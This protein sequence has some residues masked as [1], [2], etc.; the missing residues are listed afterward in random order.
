M[1]DLVRRHYDRF[2]YPGVNMLAK[3]RPCDT[4]ALNLPALWGGFN[5]VL[6]PSSQAILIAGCGTFSHY[7]FSIANPDAGIVGLDLS[8]ASLAKAKLHAR[9]H[10]CENVTF[11]QGDLLQPEVAPG[12]FH[13]IDAYGVLHHLEEPLAGLHALAD[14]LE[15]GGILRI[16]VYSRGARRTVESVRRAFRLLGITDTSAARWMFRRAARC[17]R[18]AGCIRS[19]PEAACDSGLADAFLH[20]T[21]HT[22]CIDD[23]MTLVSASSL[24]PLRFAHP[25]ALPEIPAELERLR[26]AEAEDEIYFNYVLYLGKNCRGPAPVGNGSRLLLNPALRRAVSRPRLFPLSVDGRLGSVNPVLGRGERRFLRRFVRPVPVGELDAGD[27]V[28]A[29]PYLN[30]LFLFAVRCGASSL[31]TRSPDL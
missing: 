24:T 27:M 25:G 19:L 17:S 23:L 29:E 11:L 21:V 8:E 14:R 10:R 12:P 18:L 3:V 31:P 7:P 6:P 5:G 9:V 1:T 28:K 22:F 2:P 20:P 13:F 4:Y 26:T 15:E 16:M 30:G